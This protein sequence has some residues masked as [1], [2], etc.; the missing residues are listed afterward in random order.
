VVFEIAGA[1]PVRYRVLVLLATFAGLRWGELIALRRHN[2]DLEACGIR[3]VE[4]TAQL[5]SGTLLPETPNP[6]RAA[7]RSP[8]RPS[9]CLKSAGARLRHSS[10]PAALIYQHATRDRDQAIAMALCGTTTV[11]ELVHSPLLP[12]HQGCDQRVS[13]GAGEGNRTLMTSLEG[14]GS[15]IELR[16]RGT[17]P[18]AVAYLPHLGWSVASAPRS[19]RVG[20]GWLGR[21]VAQLG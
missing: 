18:H 14:W 5:D 11:R 20:Y 10:T 7:A 17:R 1:I 6:E 4:T 8:S 9:W 3:I 13:A 16:P 2:V 15:A 19:G 12:G 21:A